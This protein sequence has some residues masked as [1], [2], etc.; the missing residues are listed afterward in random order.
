MKTEEELRK[1]FYNYT[2][3]HI[4]ISASETEPVMDVDAFIKLMK[5]LKFLNLDFVSKSVCIYTRA[6]S[7]H[8]KRHNDCDT[9]DMQPFKMPN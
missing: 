5:E 9:C 7:H 8:C 4:E 2:N 6:N 3:G 1:L